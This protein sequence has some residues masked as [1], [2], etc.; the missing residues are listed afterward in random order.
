MTEYKPVLGKETEMRVLPRKFLCSRKWPGFVLVVFLI[1]LEIPVSRSYATDPYSEI[2]PYYWTVDVQSQIRISNIVDV[3]AVR[4]NMIACIW[5]GRGWPG[6]NL[7]ARVETIDTPAWINDLGSTN[8]SRVDRIEI[9]MDYL[10]KSC[11]YHIQPA[12]PVNRLILY[13]H[14]HNV[15]LSGVDAGWRETT[16]YFLDAGFS[17]MLFWMPLEGENTVTAYGVP[18][19]AGP[20]TFGSHDEMAWVLENADGSFLRFFLEPVV[21]ALNF[22][23]TFYS[24]RDINMIGLSGGGWTT[25]LAAALDERISYSFPT[26]GSLPLYLLEGPCPFGPTGD[27]EQTWPAMYQDTASWLDI[28][29]LGSYGRGR[30]QVHVI[31]QADPWCYWGIGYRTY[32]PFITNT[33]A[34]LGAG[35]YGVFLDSSHA[36]HRISDCALNSVI[37]PLISNKPATRVAPGFSETEFCNL[38]PN[39]A[40][41]VTVLTKI[42][43]DIRVFWDFQD[44]GKDISAWNFTSGQFFISTN[45]MPGTTLTNT[46]LNLEPGRTYYCRFYATNSIFRADGWSDAA[47]FATPLPPVQ[48]LNPFQFRQRMKI[49]F[50]GYSGAGILSNFP[51]LVLF[52]NNTADSSF[53][54]DDFAYSSGADLR[55]TGLDGVTPLSFDV[56]SWD[57]GGVSVVR[58]KVP[59]ISGSNDCIWAYWGNPLC[60]GLSESASAGAAW[61]EEYAGIWH[62]MESS[63][64]IGQLDCY[65]DA[66]TK[67]RDGDDFVSSAVSTGR[68][69][70]GLLL[71]G[72]GDHIALREMVLPGAFTLSAWILSTNDSTDFTQIISRGDN[73]SEQ[74]VYMGLAGGYLVAGGKTTNSVWNCQCISLTNVTDGVWH[75]V[76]AVFDNLAQE[77]T[78]FVDGRKQISV[79]VQFDADSYSPKNTVIGKNHLFGTQY[80][81]GMIDEIRISNAKRSEDWINAQ[82]FCAASNAVFCRYGQVA[83]IPVDSDNDCLPDSWEELYGGINGLSGGNGDYDGDG[84]SDLAEYAA[85]TNP[86][87]ENSNLRIDAL[88]GTINFNVVSGRTYRIQCCTNLYGGAWFDIDGSGIAVSAS[89]T[90]VITNTVDAIMKFYRVRVVPPP[91]LPVAY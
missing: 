65:S 54:Y 10:M 77:V 55:F 36:E 68:I 73:F 35:S 15:P 52:S 89:G 23:G 32:E 14:G 34:R 13:H 63:H 1:Y 90:L 81:Q 8:I 43:G 6:T 66:T 33:V 39:S 83:A 72:E 16:R 46:A 78:G 70:K 31:N 17:V 20:V 84:L 57:T 22:A 60:T 21:S 59:Q 45:V 80:F 19:Y 37:I 58:V 75:H 25:H 2:D 4:S 79:N 56:E 82:W 7:P 87:D 24:Y 40:D 49:G 51:V 42:P 91:D 61:G 64:G 76:A 53:S 69:A 48:L 30:R 5:K 9:V 28:Y 74:G 50:A 38:A 71:N 67:R 62:L 47:K 86:M 27:A 85:G 18:G 11:V 26:A 3:A 41:M 44:R 88:P 12:R 29:I